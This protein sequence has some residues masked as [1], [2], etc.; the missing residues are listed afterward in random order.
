MKVKLNAT[1]SACFLV[2]AVLSVAVL[3]LLDI[4]WRF[5]G[6]FCDT[7]LFKDILN[8]SSV[9][10]I[11]GN[12]LLA[13]SLI[14]YQKRIRSGHPLL[15]IA[16]LIWVVL[17]FSIPTLFV[18]VLAVINLFPNDQFRVSNLLHDRINS[19]W[20]IVPLLDFLAFLL[21]PVLVLVEGHGV[22][23][24]VLSI[25]LSIPS[26]MTSVGLLF[27]CKWVTT[28]PYGVRPGK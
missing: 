15:L 5:G 2:G 10:T 20:P 27:F 14:A 3:L 8:S 23:Q 22:A 24:A 16:V 13:V 12:I 4:V 25:V 7:K 17:N 19:W 11:V 21:L 18:L 28:D 9:F 6:A 1:A 26:L